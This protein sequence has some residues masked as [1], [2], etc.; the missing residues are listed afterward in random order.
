VAQTN[1]AASGTYYI[2]ASSFLFIGA[3]DNGVFCYD[4][5]GNGVPIQYGGSSSHG[6]QQASIT[7]V[8][9]VN[10]ADSFEL[11]CYSLTRDG[12]SSLDNAGITATLIN[13][14]FDAKKSKHSQHKRSAAPKA[15][16]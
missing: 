15:P 10:S 2:S 8:V 1:A 7:D 4:T 13:S 16:K 5:T 3:T 9:T 12:S 11:W 6:F 14:A